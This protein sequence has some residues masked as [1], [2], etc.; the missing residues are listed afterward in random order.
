MAST[1]CPPPLMWREVVESFRHQCEVK[2]WQFQGRAHRASVLGD[3]PPLYLL[4]GFWGDAALFALLVW[5]LKDD[6]TCVIYDWPGWEAAP[7]QDADAQLTALA[8]GVFHIADQLGHSRFAL[9]GTSFGGL[10]ALR[11]LLDD[12]HRIERTSLQAGFA[13]R[14]LSAMER[15]LLQLAR[16]QAKSLG[17]TKTAVAIQR[18]NH[19]PWFPPFDATRW[20]FCEEQMKLTSLYDVTRRVT[21]AGRVDLRPCLAQIVPPVLVISCEGEGRVVQQAQRELVERIPRGSIVG[22]DNCGALPHVTHPHRLAKLLRGFR[23]ELSAPAV[24]LTSPRD[25]T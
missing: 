25:G 18:W 20:E 15:A 2:H 22:L 14:P 11:M 5:L 13:A 8:E 17:E 7:A 1:G 21:I 12:P 16:L 23:D 9:H 19:R 10:V 6:Y 3:G 4:N 24:E